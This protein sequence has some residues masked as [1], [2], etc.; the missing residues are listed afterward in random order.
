[1][2]VAMCMLSTNN[3]VYLST[4]QYVARYQGINRTRPKEVYCS[5]QPLPDGID[6]RIPAPFGYINTHTEPG[7][8]DRKLP[9]RGEYSRGMATR[10]VNIPTPVD[11]A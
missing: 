10:C 2:F 9:S 6:N 3:P 7:Y 11:S 4:A 5:K 8:T 1:M